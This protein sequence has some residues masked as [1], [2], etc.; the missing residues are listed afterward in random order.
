MLMTVKESFWPFELA[1]MPS[2]PSL[3]PAEASSCFALAG[4]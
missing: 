2:E 3:K 1:M 4:S